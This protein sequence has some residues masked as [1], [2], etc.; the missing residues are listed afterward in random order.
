ESYE[1]YLKEREQH[2][3]A[4]ILDACIAEVE[5]SIPLLTAQREKVR[6]LAKAVVEKKGNN[7]NAMIFGGNKK[8]SLAYSTAQALRKLDK[9]DLADVLDEKQLE[10]FEKYRVNNMGGLMW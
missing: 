10:A 2:F 4:A 7:G 3:K 8:A 6:A 1:N 9:K 5:K